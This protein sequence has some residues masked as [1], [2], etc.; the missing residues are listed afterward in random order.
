M[1]QDTQNIL[2]QSNEHF[3]HPFDTRYSSR[4]EKCC[5]ERNVNKEN[6][7][8]NEQEQPIPMTIETIHQIAQG[9][10]CRIRT[11]NGEGA[12]F[13]GKVKDVEEKEW[14]YGLFTSTHVLNDQ[15][16]VNYT[17]NHQISITIGKEKKTEHI[18]TIHENQYRITCPIHEFT[19]IEVD[20]T[21]SPFNENNEIEFVECFHDTEF[22]RNGT[23]I[24][25][26]EFG[27][28]GRRENE[29][30][31]IGMWGNQILYESTTEQH[32]SPPSTSGTIIFS[33]TGQVIGI[34]IS[35]STISTIRKEEKKCEYG[36]SM[37]PVICS[38]HRMKQSFRDNFQ[39]KFIRGKEILSTDEINKLEE[40][41]SLILTPSEPRLFEYRDPKNT[42]P[43]LNDTFYFYR[44]S[45]SWMIG[46]KTK[47]TQDQEPKD[48]QW[49]MI[50]QYSNTIDLRN[51]EKNKSEVFEFALTVAYLEELGDVY[52]QETSHELEMLKITKNPLC[53]KTS[54]SEQILFAQK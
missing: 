10:C 12:G 20:P 22:H 49:I 36:M 32:H 42:N 30:R 16:L 33:K 39:R 5:R 28:I 26:I 31:I 3:L 17:N 19:F 53:R 41:Y 29:R 7:Q 43:L 21:Q 37:Y 9:C 51:L 1:N 34:H 38:I 48:Y 25:I 40:R 14:I 6:L 11:E 35:S 50:N 2:I 27:E 52:L 46:M 45:Y 24:V 47:N 44:T 18:L 23:E 54:I 4:E 15:H 8:G 13:F